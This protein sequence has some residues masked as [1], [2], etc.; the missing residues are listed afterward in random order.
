[1]VCA[2]IV[3]R[4]LRAIA[5][6]TRRIQECGTHPAQSEGTAIVELFVNFTRPVGLLTS[7]KPRRE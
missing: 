4:A 6:T 1:M 7:Q 2:P 5:S 3:G